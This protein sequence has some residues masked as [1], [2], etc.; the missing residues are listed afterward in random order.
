MNCSKPA[1]WVTFEYDNVERS[2]VMFNANHIKSVSQDGDN[3][4]RTLIDTGD[5]VPFAVHGDFATIA[6]QVM[7]AHE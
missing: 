5:G 4:K 1:N 7:S 6:A 3:E 2:K